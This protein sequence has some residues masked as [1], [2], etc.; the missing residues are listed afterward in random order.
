MTSRITNTIVATGC[1]GNIHSGQ[2]CGNYAGNST[3][4]YIGLAYNGLLGIISNSVIRLSDD[5][6]QR[7]WNERKGRGVRTRRVFWSG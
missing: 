2:G 5:E 3:E 1:L 4:N 7:N 6:I